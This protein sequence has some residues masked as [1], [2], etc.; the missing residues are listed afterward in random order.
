[1]LCHVPG[2][3]LFFTRESDFRAVVLT[4]R[5]TVWRLFRFAYRRS[6]PPPS[7]PPSLT[8]SRHAC[9]PRASS[10]D[11]A[12]TSR[13][14]DDAKAT[15]DGEKDGEA[16]EGMRDGDGASRSCLTTVACRPPAVYRNPCLQHVL[17]ITPAPA[18][19][20]SVF[21]FLVDFPVSPIVSYPP[22]SKSTRSRRWWAST[23][24]GRP[25]PTRS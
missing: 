12:G 10:G 8:A 7:R 17:I 2:C 22:P 24:A 16:V 3:G 19:A 11:P 20:P 5:R 23:R 18:P 14:K 4:A 9:G 21:F 25:S 1:M 15:G 6:P 13:E